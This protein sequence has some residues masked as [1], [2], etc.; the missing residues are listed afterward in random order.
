MWYAY[1]VVYTCD[2]GSAAIFIVCRLL[3]C[4]NHICERVCHD[5]TCDSCAL[6]PDHVTHCPCGATSLDQLL[7]TS[8]TSCLDP[9]P[10]C[11]AVC[12]RLLPCSTSG[13]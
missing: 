1:V 9:I 4:E 5:G 3:D 6:L 12:R 13:D 11:N 10:T 7:T 8:R 2:S